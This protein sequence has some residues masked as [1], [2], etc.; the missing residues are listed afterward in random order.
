MNTAQESELGV[1]VHG[2]NIASI[3]QADDCVLLSDDINFLKNL[4]TLTTD[5]CQKYHVMLAPEKTKLLSFSAPRH[6]A[7]IDY[8]ELVS[9]LAIAGF[10][11]KF[12]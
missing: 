3:G 4:L 6:K 12:S 9:D 11:V 2:V 10:P 5:Y 1:D 8:L 7:T